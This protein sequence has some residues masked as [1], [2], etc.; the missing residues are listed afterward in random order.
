M[1]FKNR[2]GAPESIHMRGLSPKN[3]PIRPTRLSCRG[4]GGLLS[5]KFDHFCT[6]YFTFETNSGKMMNTKRK[7]SMYSTLPPSTI[8]ICKNSTTKPKIH[9]DCQ[10]LRYELFKMHNLRISIGEAADRNLQLSRAG[11]NR[12][13]IT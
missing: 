11:Y 8:R 10:S 13:N 7:L 1:K 2:L 12:K 5:L 6:L 9:S 3:E 4:G